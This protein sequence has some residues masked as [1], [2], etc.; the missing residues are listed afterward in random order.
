MKIAKKTLS[1][2]MAVLMVLSCWVWVDPSALNVNAAED[3][4][5]LFAYF[6]GTSIE[7]QTIHLAISEDGLNYTALREN[8]P[9]IIP[10]KGTGCVRD[11]YLWYNENDGYYYILATDLDFTDTGSDYSDNSESFIV[12][13]SKDLIN[14]FDETMIDVKAILGRLGIN[15]N[16]MQAVWAPQ[17]LWDGTEFVVY[18]SLQ[19][20]ATSN[21]SWNPLTIVYL[22]T[23][24]LLDESKYHEY[25][26]IHNPG[27]HV[28]DADIIKKPGTNQ[29][30][31]F[32]KDESATSGIQNIFYL[33]SDN[34]PTGP[35]YAP[36]NANAGRGPQLFSWVGQNLE[37]CN[38]FFDDNGNLVTYVDEYDYKNAN[39]QKEAHFHVSKTSDFVNY[40]KVEE[41]EYNINSLSPRHGSVIKI[42]NDK[43]KELAE[44]S[45]SISSSS[46]SEGDKLSSHLV[47]RY[48]TTD[49]AKY[50]AV[51]KTEDL[52]ITDN[53]SIN[54]HMDSSGSYYAEFAGAGAEINLANIIPGDLNIKDGFT[55]TFT[56]TTPVSAGP[57]T[58]FFDISN[59]W[60]QRGGNNGNGVFTDEAKAK[61]ECY[62]HM[63][64][65]AE[66]NGL[67]VGAYNG[68]A[69]TGSWT[70]AS[71]GQNY[72]DGYAHKYV[73][74]FA[75]GNM[76]LYIDGVLAM[77]RNRFNMNTEYGDNFLKDNWYKEIGNSVMRI[78]KSEWSDPLFTGKMQNLCIYDCT[79]SYYDVEEMQKQFDIAAGNVTLS[80]IV[81]PETVYMTP[82]TGASTKAQYYINNTLDLTNKIVDLEVNPSNTAGNVEFYI[83][84][85]IDAK[86]EVTTV[87]KVD[88]NNDDV[89]DLGDVV[90]AEAGATTGTLEGKSLA[91]YITNGH[92][93]Y[94]TA[95]LY[96]DTT[97]GKRGIYRQENLTA[98]W[99]FTI[100]MSD[101]STQT[102]YAYSTLYAPYYQPVGAAA[103]AYSGKGASG[104]RQAWLGSIAWVEGVHSAT[105]SN[106]QGAS[107]WYP[108]TDNF[109]PMLGK[110]YEKDANGNHYNN[111]RPSK[112]WIQSGS[113]NHFE[114][115][116]YLE[117]NGD[118]HRRVSVVS[119]LA[120]LTV[121]T[122]RYNNEKGATF[123]DIPNF[124]VGYMITDSENADSGKHY[125]ADYT[126]NTTNMGS[127]TGGGGTKND[128]GDSIYND[129]TGTKII[130]NASDTA[131]WCQVHYYGNWNRPI[132]TG[133]VQL[134]GAAGAEETGGTVKRSA[135]NYNYVQI[136]VTG[137]NKKDLR[138]L[139]FKASYIHEQN[140][141][142]ASFSGEKGYEKVNY[143]QALREAADAVGNPSNANLSYYDALQ[144]ALNDLAT[145]LTLNY[146]YD[147]K[148]IE[149]S[150]YTVGTDE[151]VTY[152]FSSGNDK[153]IKYDVPERPGYTFM[154]WATDPNAETGSTTVT[155][156]LRPTFYAVWAPCK[157]KVF[158]DNMFDFSKF[159][160]GGNLT[161]NQRTET[162]FTVTST[163]GD[164]NTGFSYDIPVEPGKTYVFKADVKLVNQVSGGYD[165]Y[166]HTLDSNKAGETTA[167]PDTSN[168]AHRE[169]NVYISLTGQ[170]TKTN[171]YIRFT[172]GA[173]T[174]YIRIRFDANA[175][176]NTIEVNN[177]RIYE[178]NGVSYETPIEVTYDSTY[179]E[180]PL[181]I[182]TREGYKFQ[183]WY[184][185]AEA[186]YW[187]DDTVKITSDAYVYS[188][189]ALC[190]EA[191][192]DDLL[193]VDFDTDTHNQTISINPFENDKILTKSG[194]DYRIKGLSTDG[195]NI[196]NTITGEF[197]T[198]NVVDNS[199]TYTPKSTLVNAVDSIWY[200]V[201][202]PGL[203]DKEVN[204][205]KIFKSIR[206]AP[207]SNVLYEDD[208]F[209]TSDSST[210]VATWT[211]VT[212]EKG[213][214]KA[215]ASTVYGYD[216]AY[217]G[218][219][220][221]YSNG[222]AL[223]ATVDS[224]TK[225]SQIQTF[226]FQGTA[227]DL[228][229]QCGADTGVMVVTVKDSK[230]NVLKAYVVD[231]YYSGSYG[232]LNQVPLV[233]AEL[234]D[235]GS[236]TVQ[237]AAMYLSSAGAVKGAQTRS[238]F[239]LRDV[240]MYSAPMTSAE[241]LYEALC[242]VDLEEVFEA[243]DLEVIWFDEGSIFA[244]DMGAS[245]YSLR[246][247][248]QTASTRAVPDELVNIIDSIR[249][250]NPL[251]YDDEYYIATEKNAQYYNIMNNLKNGTLI[252]GNGNFTY[253]NYTT[254]SDNTA[255]DFETYET[256]GS[257]E[258]FY[259]TK[260][261]GALTFSIN[262]VALG[263]RI[264]VSLRAAAG[265]PT[266][267]IGT[268]QQAITS[269]TEM[270]YDITDYV[271]PDGTV[272]IQNT[273]DGL[274]AIGNVKI[275]GA[276]AAPILMS[277]FNMRSAR[278]MMMAPANDVD[279]NEPVEEPSTD[280]PEEPSTEET[281]TE[282]VTTE[283]TTTEEVTTEEATTEE[284]TTEEVTTEETTTEA[285]STE[286]P[287][288]PDADEDSN[289]VTKESFLE[290]ING[291]IDFIV[292]LIKKIFSAIDFMQNI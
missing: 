233:G 122:S 106:Y 51:T 183:G 156:G 193:I 153:L 132:A 271:N 89:N 33:I 115:V 62:L 283:E 247:T 107:H 70:W 68:P 119:P 45:S 28:I 222:T 41:S 95:G 23:T 163:A 112:Y 270:Y 103:E 50:N 144:T 60:S 284:T 203:T 31:M 164:G 173:N 242:E 101:G 252:S 83:P 79:L 130:N 116:T 263:G 161:L 52:K 43:Y 245:T 257:N 262:K 194:E 234:D 136:N 30:Y 258:E 5:Y 129:P 288:T 236:Y 141:T 22:K 291:L 61:A 152:D 168:G 26:V 96:I 13:R 251:N 228:Y 226:T 169:G 277:T 219:V 150:A 231:T 36:D 175:V 165:M 253:V 182:P 279:F 145:P 221:L 25:G 90:F 38:S 147:G 57:N 135:W 191:L 171:P 53:G 102:Y 238:A 72:N 224:T 94:R 248:A 59:N 82:S 149:T 128:Y 260:N 166:I 195:E 123:A 58:R 92:F 167:T 109:L 125:F 87:S 71:Q 21:G 160:I 269:S 134:I 69:T 211:T 126:G 108:H 192:N 35:Y 44:N 217:E 210:N 138:D 98:E 48:F 278:M 11:P 199:I 42:S 131:T 250:Y 76:I 189:W 213:S 208:R 197:G 118:N 273:G 159:N 232:T 254:E 239:G 17:V 24:N 177:I 55:I 29:Y 73:I 216:S 39:G 264:M 188:K 179:G 272:T 172:A 67:Y 190:S 154:G 10:S 235:F 223:K 121:D 15:N 237:V 151:T 54:M 91:S 143:K 117:G 148:I 120:K 261:T 46:I 229:G 80:R 16:N 1:I 78:G 84:G 37:G 111:E 281:T 290:K 65:V 280:V 207:A 140:Y 104:S 241:M 66:N 265:T 137:V 289:E 97:G 64:P 292:S 34:G 4:S 267:K 187:N 285:P 204:A 243:D 275:T 196:V 259:L 113:N 56:A 201:E 86:I 63:S 3:S 209:T 32:Y 230:N 100:T 178:D 185:T 218:N 268:A 20:D 81:V 170:T 180:A 2:V 184:D 9:V 99:K 27:R 114:S 266:A 174:A 110:L 133:T 256:K 274:L 276:E 157:Y 198:F 206:V 212:S 205:E 249:I 220:G 6:T 88:D 49:N 158:F 75:D 202:I 155:A 244:S 93:V 286:E 139:V 127:S 77:K 200:H 287:T 19:C 214:T 282:E 255:I 18:F 246:G 7:G 14:W 105:T 8:K 74:T 186:G 40:T 142:T 146:N 240:T 215:S 176:G 162:G 47:G 12:W 124:K 227:F 225:R 85:A 181:P